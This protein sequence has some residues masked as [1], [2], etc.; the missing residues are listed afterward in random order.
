MK[1]YNLSPD[2][3]GEIL[4]KAVGTVQNWR[5]DLKEKYAPPLN[6]IRLL[7]LELESRKAEKVKS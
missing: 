1:D 5:A 7:K 6:Q 3:V 4:G 2:D